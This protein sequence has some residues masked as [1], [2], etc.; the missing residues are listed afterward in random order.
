M[1]WVPIRGAVRA[2]REAARLEQRELARRSGVTERTVRLLESRRAPR[3]MHA[4]TVKALAGALACAP[5]DLA[6]WVTRAR[7]ATDDEEDAPITDGALPPG[8]T[9]GRRAA[10]ERALGRDHATLTLDDGT[11][12]PLLGPTLLRRLHIACAAHADQRLAIRG[13]AKEAEPLPARAAPVLDARVGEGARFLV[14]RTVARGVPFYVTVFTR[15]LAHTTALL[16]AVE[17]GARVELIARVHVAPP[18][19]A[20]DWKGFFVFEKRPKPHP[21]ALVITDVL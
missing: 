8:S 7:P 15:M 4:S 20:T 1:T 13:V 11:T 9:L 2:L 10:R 6:T 21:F 3:T 19:P 12:L 14:A 16:D 5:E 18:D 17:R